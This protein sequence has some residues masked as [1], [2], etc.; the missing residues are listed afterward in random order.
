MYLYCG[1]R[2]TPLVW[3]SRSAMPAA[4]I[5][6]ITFSIWVAFARIAALASAAWVTIPAEIVATSGTRLA[7]A[8]ADTDSRVPSLL[9]MTAGAASWA[10]AV[11]A[12]ALTARAEAKIGRAHV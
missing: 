7:S 8:C 1:L 9:A 12:M 11:M 3:I 2:L 5:A 10:D 6:A 4:R